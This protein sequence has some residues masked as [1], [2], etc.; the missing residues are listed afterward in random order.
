[1]SKGKDYSLNRVVTL[2]PTEKITFGEDLKELRELTPRQGKH[3]YT[4]AQNRQE[5]RAWH[6]SKTRK[7]H[8]WRRM[9]DKKV[10]VGKV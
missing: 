3:F 5:A 7:A 4:E 9:R 1:M 2:S 10:G 6:I 8:G